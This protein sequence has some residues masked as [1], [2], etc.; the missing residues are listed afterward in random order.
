MA[1]N[2]SKLIA[3]MVRD[4]NRS[5][6]EPSAPHHFAKQ[7]CRPVVE[8][9]IDI[10]RTSPEDYNE[11]FQMMLSS[12]ICLVDMDKIGKIEPGPEGKL[13]DFNMSALVFFSIIR[14]YTHYKGDWSKVIKH[15]S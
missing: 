8:H 13:V 6:P 14:V 9:L 5:L 1:F 4:C 3:D 11:F 7:V 2:A 12:L 10:Q 15:F